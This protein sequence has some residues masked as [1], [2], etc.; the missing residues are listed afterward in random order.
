MASLK[1]IR[2]SI[3]AVKD[4]PS[5]SRRTFC[6][7]AARRY[8]TYTDDTISNLRIDANTRVIY[9]GMQTSGCHNSQPVTKNLQGSPERR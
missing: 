4:H 5:V 6:S 7:S 8:A 2:S 1:A 9:Q 3:A